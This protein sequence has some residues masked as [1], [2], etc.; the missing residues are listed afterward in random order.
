MSGN[1]MICEFVLG[2]RDEVYPCEDNSHVVYFSN[3]ITLQSARF[4]LKHV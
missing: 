2:V 3:S 1:K 4:H